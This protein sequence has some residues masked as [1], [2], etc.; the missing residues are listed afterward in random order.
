MPLETI[1]DIPGFSEPFSSLS[2]LL[3]AGVFLV[4]GIYLVMNGRGKL[5][6]VV[7][8]MVF[9]FSF[10]FLLSMSGVYHLLEIGGTGRMI[11]Q[12]L[13]H[14]GIFFLIA[15]TFTPVHT[16]LFRGRWQWGMLLLIWTIA[17]TNI[18]LKVVY[19]DAIEEWIGLLMFLGMGWV[20]AISGILLYRRFGLNFIKP[21]LYG[22][23]AYTVGAVME[24][25]R[26]P[27][28]IPGHIGPHE[29]FHI[30]VLFGL[31]YHFLFIYTFADH[32]HES[33]IT[34]DKNDIYFQENKSFFS[35]KIKN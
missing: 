14:A 5:S 13:D 6:N 35:E 4:M 22:A 28:L 12:R 32:D 29:L 2:H 31:G 7:S 26:W 11:L 23:F 25:L 10:L 1:V 34:I 33:P 30:A 24:F 21:L 27:E 18:T 9:V 19:F 15:G 8:L 17:I 20:G 3:A 16:I